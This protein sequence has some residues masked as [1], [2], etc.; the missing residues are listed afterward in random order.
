MLFVHYANHFYP[1]YLESRAGGDG[2]RCYH[3]QSRHARHRL[4]SNK[5]AG[6]RLHYPAWLVRLIVLLLLVANVINLGADVGA[7]GAALQL[8]LGGKPRLYTVAF[9]ILSI[10][11]EIFIGYAIYAGFLKWL[12]LSLFAYVAVVFA[13]HVHGRKRCWG[14]LCTPHVHT[15]QCDGA[16]RCARH[17]DQPVFV[18][19]AG[20]LGGR[21]PATS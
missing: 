9:G 2:S 12:T 17:H 18:F 14:S 21:R 19:L 8:L 13:V 3:T 5:R 15:W 16:S 20:G 6:L 10:A 11:A 7:M 4:L 1:L